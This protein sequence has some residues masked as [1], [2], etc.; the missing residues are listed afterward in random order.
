MKIDRR[1]VNSGLCIAGTAGGLLRRN[2]F[3][4]QEK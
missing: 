3:P 2:I 4:S 1:T